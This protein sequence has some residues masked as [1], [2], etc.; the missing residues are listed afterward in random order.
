VYGKHP[1]RR[2]EANKYKLKV[3]QNQLPKEKADAKQQQVFTGIDHP[4]A[5]IAEQLRNADG[6]IASN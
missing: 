4:L 3:N 5:V 2:F 6:D 1:A